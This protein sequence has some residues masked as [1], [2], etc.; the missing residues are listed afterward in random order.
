MVALRGPDS[1]ADDDDTVDRRPPAAGFVRRVIATWIDMALFCGLC[2][3]LAFPVASVVHWS[4]VPT[5]LDEVAAAVSDASWLSRAS[6]VMGMWIALWWCYFVVGWGLAG[7]TPGKW[8]L[9]LRVTDHKGR[10][11]I[12]VTRAVMR[13]FGYAVSSITLGVGHLLVM[14]RA[15]RRAL[16][17]MLAG[18]RVIRR[19]QGS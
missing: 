1:N 19:G 14:F 3:V 4:A 13:L 12:G 15:D 6:G 18:T 11:P 7:A 16:H 5:N 8:V 9:G 17:D 10:C 2:A